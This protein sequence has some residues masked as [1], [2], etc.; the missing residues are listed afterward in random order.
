MC[1]SATTTRTFEENSS[2]CFLLALWH[3]RDFSNSM[4]LSEFAFNDATQVKKMHL[5]GDDKII[6]GRFR[7]QSFRPTKI[8]WQY[9]M[10]T[11]ILLFAC[12]HCRVESWRVAPFGFISQHERARCQ[13]PTPPCV[14]EGE[15]RF[16]LPPIEMK[17][18][19]CW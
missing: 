5:D 1:G 10:S 7:A 14:G 15:S 13:C 19:G 11:S 12:S 17:S 9:P 4:N 3:L 16:D 18:N 8:K 2:T 6:C